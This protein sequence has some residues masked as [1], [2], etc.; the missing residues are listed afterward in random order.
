MTSSMTHPDA[1]AAVADD[2]WSLLLGVL[3]AGVPVTSLAQAAAVATA[4]VTACAADADAHLRVDLRPERVELS[5]QNRSAEAVTP[6]DVDLCHRVTRSLQELG[7]AVE[8]P[9]SSPGAHPAQRLEIAI[10]ALDIAAVLPFWRAVMGYADS[11][12]GA[13]V[14]NAVVDPAGL[15]PAIWFQQMD[16][17]RPQRNRIHLDLAVAPEEA[18]GRIRAALDAG[19][20]LV[21]DAAARAFWVLADPEG[22]EICICTWQDR[23]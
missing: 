3:H 21:S 13:E 2:G 9:V 4:A 20:T 15:G 23:D 14:P 17:P 18:L 6:L 8:A 10:D 22:N 11:P 1:A 5:L 16:Q 7:L 19:G 12:A